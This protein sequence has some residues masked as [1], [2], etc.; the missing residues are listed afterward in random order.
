MGVH[1][2]ELSGHDLQPPGAAVQI[3]VEFI[4]RV[5]AH[6]VRQRNASQLHP[7]EPLLVTGIEIKPSAPHPVVAVPVFQAIDG[8][9]NASA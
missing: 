9:G 7:S 8:R 4:D 6:G 3:Q 2:T 1:Q 5:T